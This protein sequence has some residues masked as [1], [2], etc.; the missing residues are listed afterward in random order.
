MTMILPRCVYMTC[1][2]PTGT[3]YK[4]ILSLSL[5]IRAEKGCFPP[6]GRGN[7]P[8]QCPR[9]RNRLLKSSCERRVKRTQSLSFNSLWVTNNDLRILTYVTLLVPHN[10]DSGRHSRGLFSLSYR[11]RSPGSQGGRSLKQSVSGRTWTRTQD[12]FLTARNSLLH[13]AP[14]WWTS[15]SDKVLRRNSSLFS[16][17][18]IG[19]LSL[20]PV[21]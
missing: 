5:G 10:R 7:S 2:S 4:V 14:N 17:S 21:S 19:Q 12:F 9:E 11:S 8:W 6:T 1:P 18:A 15:H 16:E 13:Y 20:Y 3:M